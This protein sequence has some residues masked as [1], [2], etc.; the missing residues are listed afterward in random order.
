MLVQPAGASLPPTDAF[1]LDRPALL[2]AA[3]R[4]Q[5]FGWNAGVV[6]SATPAFNQGG[7]L[8]GHPRAVARADLMLV[9]VVQRIERQ[10][11]FDQQRFERFYSQ[12]KVRRNRL[13]TVI[14]A[15]VLSVGEVALLAASAAGSAAFTASAARSISF[16]VSATSPSLS[17]PRARSLAAS[18]RFETATAPAGRAGHWDDPEHSLPPG[19]F[20]TGDYVAPDD[21]LNDALYR[22]DSWDEVEPDA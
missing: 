6:C 17:T 1:R 4:G 3:Q 18:A 22:A 2:D 15:I 7:I 21:R 20:L 16:A 9:G 8:M 5:F 10:P 11:F 19:S 13:V 12:G 14:V